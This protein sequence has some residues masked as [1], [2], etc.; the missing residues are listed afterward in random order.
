[1]WSVTDP[2]ATGYSRALPDA[3]AALRRRAEGKLSGAV[4]GTRVR[5]TAD[6]SVSSFARVSDIDFDADASVTEI[7]LAVITE[8][9]IDW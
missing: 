8:P 7:E 4:V 9:D 1:M 3:S 6:L 5:S 2:R